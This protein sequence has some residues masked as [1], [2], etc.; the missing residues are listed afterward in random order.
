IEVDEALKLV[1]AINGN[2]G[3]IALWRTEAIGASKEIGRGDLRKKAGELAG[4]PGGLHPKRCAD[5]DK[6]SQQDSGRASS[7]GCERTPDHGAPQS[8][9][10]R[11][12]DAHPIGF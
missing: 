3:G 2:N 6:G 12:R 11:L 10:V 5:R 4:S 8:V 9:A 7:G 1:A